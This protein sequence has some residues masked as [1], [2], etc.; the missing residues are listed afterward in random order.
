MLVRCR[1]RGS[2]VGQGIEKGNLPRWSLCA[3]SSI[4][5]LTCVVQNLA[6]GSYQCD[7]LASDLR[8]L[9]PPSLP[10]SVSACVLVP[11]MVEACRLSSSRESFVELRS[12]VLRDLMLAIVGV[13]CALLGLSIANRSRRRGSSSFET[14]WRSY[15]TAS[16]E[17][18]C[19]SLCLRSCRAAERRLSAEASDGTLALMDQAVLGGGAPKDCFV[20]CCQSQE[21]LKERYAASESLSGK[22]ARVGVTG[23][24]RSDNGGMWRCGEA[25][26]PSAGG[27][28]SPINTQTGRHQPCCFLLNQEATGKM[29]ALRLV[30]LYVHQV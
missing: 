23:T 5:R 13:A 25:F 11:P 7:V 20:T 12:D 24:Y 26:G 4:V 9:V 10:P 19:G 15:C 8:L 3:P 22:S 27:R 16:S 1:R 2:G 17:S 29:N 28:V 18:G 21:E 14:R 30:L 6:T